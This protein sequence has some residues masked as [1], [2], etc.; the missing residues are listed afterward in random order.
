MSTG[1]DS[2]RAIIAAL[3]ANLGIA[4][5]KFFG[6]LVTR[7]AS[8]LAESIHSVADSGNQILLIVGGRRSKRSATELHQFGFGRERYFWAFVV[9][10]VLFTLG[11]AFALFEGIEKILHPHEIESPAWAIGILGVSIVLEA[12]SFHTA[13]REALP[14]KG[15]GSWSS[16]IRRSKSP[17]IPV[18]LLEDTGALVG[19]VLALAAIIL[20][21]VTGNGVWDGIGT[22]AIGTLLVVIAIVL[23][24]EMKS[25]LIGEAASDDDQAAIAAAITNAP[26]VNAL[27]NLQT[28]HH[29]PESILV[30]AKVEF[31]LDLTMRE[32][33]AVI[34]DAEDRVRSAVPHVDTVYLEPDVDRARGADRQ[35]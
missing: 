5:A 10:I 28:E 3:L 33:A 16:F 9:S 17:E 6:F 13:R 34:D 15:R 21:V 35:S 31:D 27:L 24:I 1:G 29:G 7:S 22:T 2:N 8:M 12:M 11:G 25:L 32:L 14:L 26:R 18:V 20:A 19:L 30:T 23:S 4:V